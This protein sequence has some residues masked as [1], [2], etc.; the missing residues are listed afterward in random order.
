MY[1]VQ[2]T[3]AI[4]Y[5]NQRNPV[6]MKE[7]NLENVNK[8]KRQRMTQ[9][10]GVNVIMCDCCFVLPLFIFMSL[11]SKRRTNL[12]ALTHN[13][14]IL[15]CWWLHEQWTVFCVCIIHCSMVVEF[16]QM[17]KCLC[18]QIKRNEVFTISQH[19]FLLPNWHKI[20]SF[21]FALCQPPI[22]FV[23]CPT[24]FFPLW[25]A[26]CLSLRVRRVESWCSTTSYFFIVE[27]DSTEIN[28]A[29]LSF[30][31]IN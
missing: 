24:K 5:S 21:R 11:G 7:Q 6:K 27:P 12:Q 30:T 20:R 10:F 25:Y 29:Y 3:I 2:C 4:T 18:Y 26:L 13:F 31:I 15:L 16:S 19:H 9:K 22:P 28:F 17:E 23:R 14:N 8:M 1:N